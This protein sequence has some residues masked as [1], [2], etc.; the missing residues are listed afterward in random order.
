MLLKCG[1]SAVSLDRPSIHS[2]LFSGSLLRRQFLLTLRYDSEALHTER[3]FPT[4]GAGTDLRS[5][6]LLNSGLAGVEQADVL[7]L[8]GTNPR[9]EVC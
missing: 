1:V 9:Y 7:L 4:T 6:Y 3:F 8:V 5:Q 2:H